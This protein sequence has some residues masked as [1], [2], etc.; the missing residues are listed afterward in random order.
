M[1]IVEQRNS[2]MR[3]PFFT[4]DPK[5]VQHEPVKE[6]YLTGDKIIAFAVVSDNPQE[7]VQ[8]VRCLLAVKTFWCFPSLLRMLDVLE[9]ENTRIVICTSMANYCIYRGAVEKR[10][11]RALLVSTRPKL[12]RFLFNTLGMSAEY[13]VAAS[14][15]L[16]SANTR[17]NTKVYLHHG[18]LHPSNTNKTVNPLSLIT[19]LTSKTI[20]AGFRAVF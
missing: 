11:T 13:A 15:L 7:D 1:L 16:T 20:A 12:L 10:V 5:T 6:L 17:V 2:F 4:Y 14:K 19:K 8:L 9:L 18:F 3:A